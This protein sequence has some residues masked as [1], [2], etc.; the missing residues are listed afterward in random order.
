MEAAPDPLLGEIEAFLAETGLTPTA[1]GRDAMRDP[2]FVF[3]LRAGRELR[4]ATSR[5]ARRQMT[6]YR[7]CGEFG[8]EQEVAA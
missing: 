3:G 7:K 2:N 4:R 8:R 6:Q 1:F 5:R